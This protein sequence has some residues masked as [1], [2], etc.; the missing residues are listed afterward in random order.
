M[1]KSLLEEN[2]IK[3]SIFDKSKIPLRPGL[4]L[5]LV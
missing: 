5:D 3:M 1:C 4:T 2:V